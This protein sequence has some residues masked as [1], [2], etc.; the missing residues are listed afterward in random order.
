MNKESI[1]KTIK[2]INI[3]IIYSIILGVLL[4]I[5]TP[6]LNSIQQQIEIDK[7]Y[8]NAKKGILIEDV[9]LEHAEVVENLWEPVDGFTFQIYAKSGDW[10]HVHYESQNESF[11]PIWFEI[12]TN[13][14]H[15]G[16]SWGI[17]TKITFQFW[18][19]AIYTIGVYN[20]DDYQNGY[21]TFF[22]IVFTDEYDPPECPL[23]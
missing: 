23:C 14:W 21:I 2:E 12:D 4:A 6:V 5:L 15:L 13:S 19:S 17:T 8:K 20:Y 16:I 11:C 9:Y 18:E 10:C 3:I 1:L 22:L 7:L